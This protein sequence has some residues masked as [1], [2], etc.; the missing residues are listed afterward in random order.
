MTATISLPIH[1]QA[2]VSRLQPDTSVLLVGNPNAGKTSLFN[3]LTG[4][5]AKTANFAG[6]TI[7]CHTGTWRTEAGDLQLIDLPG[8]YSLADSADEERL[9]RDAIR[10]EAPNLPRAKAVILLL[11][12]T[13]LQRNLFLASQV[14]ELGVP[15]IIALNMVDLAR[16][17]GIRIEKHK[18][19]RELNCPVVP[20]VAR[21]GWG[22]DKLCAELDRLLKRDTVATKPTTCSLGCHG[23]PFQ[24]RHS[25]AR[26]ITEQ[27]THTTERSSGDRTERIDRVLTH[28]VGGVVAFM[29]VMFV[30]FLMIFWGAQYPMDAI[31]WMFDHVGGYVDQVIGGLAALLPAGL[32]HDVLVHDV[33]SLL[34]QGV[35]GGVGG[36]LVFLPQI[37]ILFFFLSLLEDTGYMARAAFVMD[38]LMRRVGLP[39]KAFVPMLS[40]HAC[41]V[42]AIM[43]TRAIEDKRD[44]L[45][46]MLVLP[47]LSC[48]ARLP[49]YT[50]IV[51]L[52]VPHRPVLAAMLFTG[53]YLLG[54][55][56]A[57]SMALVFKRTV[58]PGQTRPLVL[59]LPT[60]KVPS[61]SNA[62]RMMLDRAM[63]FVRRAGTVI[64][65]AS[66]ILWSLAHY[67]RSAP[68]A[69]AVTLQ[70][71]SSELQRQG[72]VA[73]AQHL[74]DRADS[75]IS[76]NNL[77]HSFAGMIGHTIEP[78]LR[79]LG[80]DWRMGIGL[81][82]SFAAREVFVSTMSVVYG[83][84]PDAHEGQLYN[85]LRHATDRS[86]GVPVFSVATCVSLLI[87]YVLA[88][89]CVST[90][91]VM[92]R[93]T[94]GWKWPLFQFAYMGGLAYIG[95]LLAF[96]MITWVTA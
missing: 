40:A 52:L 35:I 30:V 85:T 48:S 22:V 69:D 29:A 8:L 59:E 39:G 1:P 50:M 41:A 88:M 54:I 19:S 5:R 12:A 55:V 13:Q 71:R 67:P 95:S 18:L 78:V 4:L 60:Y 49:I 11:D 37:C 93:E 51:A 82:S 3:R 91:A 44:R 21:S 26:N 65:L 90:M 84:G 81:I 74:L 53:A 34:V 56:A 2:S 24:A 63:I 80:F 83:V 7:E 33:R 9:A 15:T 89:Q 68:P 10:G 62:M 66:V 16:R 46:S 25:W 31:Q 94:G 47:L 73:R 72:Q 42:P 86:G 61:L 43:A 96:Q 14:L 32:M 17:Q 20:I 76:Q 58:L 79:P 92:R 27:V 75:L 70:H 23:C 57:L 36:V 45:V 64:L 28:P 38:R 6:T 87:F 77:D